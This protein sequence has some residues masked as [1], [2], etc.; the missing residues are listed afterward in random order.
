VTHTAVQPALVEADKSDRRFCTHHLNADLKSRSIRGGAVT[1]SAQA[2]KFAL[3]MG[4]TA[5]L[6]RLLTPNDFGLVAM[7]AAFT[8]FV[9]LF[10]DLGLSMA[11]V[12]RAEITHAQVST[13]F[14]INVALSTLLM[15]I[16]A[17]LA[18]GVAWFYG[19][20]RLIWIMLA[21]ASTFILGGLSAQHT[22]LLQRQMRFGAL[23]IIEIAALVGGMAAGVLLAWWSFGYWA[24][25]A[26]AAVSELVT[27]ALCWGLSGWKPGLPRRDCAV[28]PMLAFGGN[29][30]GAGVL[31]YFGSNFD[32][33]MIGWWWG[34]GPLALYSKAYGLL[35]LPL[36]QV[37]APVAAVAIPAMSRAVGD[38]ARYRC[39]YLR[40][41]EQIT[42][43]TAPG[44]ALMIVCSD[45]VVSVL[46]GPQWSEAATIFSILGVAALV[47][48]VWNSTGWVFVSQDRMR[49]LLHFQ[50]LD[51]LA[52]ITSI[53]AGLRW[54]G[55]GVAVGVGIRY[56]VML[57]VL[58]RTLGR[59]GPIRE[60]DLYR[61]I[62]LP[63][64]IAGIC[65]IGLILFRY[66][67]APSNNLLGLCGAIGITGV[68]AT[69][70]LIVWPAGRASLRSLM[71][72]AGMM[73]G[74]KSIP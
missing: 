28:G 12:Q 47:L 65:L 19:E 58:F 30:T 14:W 9:A 54:G 18:P 21:V 41:V 26:M 63:L 38:P 57:P 4:S 20:P 68:L 60:S 56:Y 11:T 27:M 33:V 72:T 24:L 45:M 37:N 31:N 52:K 10:K 46:L 40:T 61:S 29:L 1:I 49:E 3:Q 23:A 50:A 22:A 39:A 35:T 67:A 8:G 7:V 13:L 43:V 42:L 48:P 44:I 70:S 17:A 73:A 15:C 5:V 34:S 69:A 71:D 66:L 53:L 62:A 16:A 36:R 51:F 32:N 2:I 74:F 59:H 64:G 25:V 55:I 6:A